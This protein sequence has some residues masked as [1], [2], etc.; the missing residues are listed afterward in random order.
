M[1]TSSHDVRNTLLRRWPKPA[2]REYKLSL[3]NKGRL[4]EK[5]HCEGEVASNLISTH[6]HKTRDALGYARNELSQAS[7]E[8]LVD[9]SDYMMISRLLEVYEAGTDPFYEHRTQA[10]AVPCCSPSPAPESA[11]SFLEKTTQ[12]YPK[13]LFGSGRYLPGYRSSIDGTSSRK[14][15]GYP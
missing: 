15:H 7:K 1:K 6:T 13:E 5:T 11:N 12:L 9:S 3:M 8:H 4:S 14:R 2:R 10:G